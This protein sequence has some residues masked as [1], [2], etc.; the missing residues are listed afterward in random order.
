MPKGNWRE[1]GDPAKE[2]GLPLETPIA[3]KSHMAVKV[4]KTSG[5]KKGKTVTVINGLEHE[6]AHLRSLLKSLK[7]NCGTGGTLKGS[8][9][10]LQGDQVA[11]IMDF[12][13]DQGYCPKR[14]GG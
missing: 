13:R 5:G 3:T 8:S 1:F 11:K 6:N 4:Q 12:L 2:I 14:S 7:R 9:I 10:E